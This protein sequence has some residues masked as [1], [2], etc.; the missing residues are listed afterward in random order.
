MKW[1]VWVAIALCFP[2]SAFGVQ[3][4]E[5]P[6]PTSEDR[7]FVTVAV[8]MASMEPQSITISGSEIRLVF[9]GSIG[10]PGSNVHTVE[11]GPLQPGIYSIVVVYE[12][13]NSSGDFLFSEED[14]PVALAVS[15][16][17]IP[18]LEEYALGGL[19][20]VMGLAGVLMARR[21]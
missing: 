18:T 8:P 10:F 6:N 16:P 4:I 13:T 15:A 19:A 14:P 20:V 5:P 11:F 9:R 7:I 12:F 17:A 2:V 21:L 3:S 1:S